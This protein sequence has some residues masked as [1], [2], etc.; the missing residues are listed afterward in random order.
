MDDTEIIASNATIGS[1]VNKRNLLAAGVT[2]HFVD[3]MHLGNACG[4]AGR[5]FGRRVHDAANVSWGQWRARLGGIDEDIC[6]VRRV[7]FHLGIMIFIIV[8]CGISNV[9]M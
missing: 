9:L 7:V 6:I 4:L 8:L 3:D 2:G 5:P 1:P